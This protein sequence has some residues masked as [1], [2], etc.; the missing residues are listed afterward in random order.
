M[1][2]WVMLMDRTTS[3][4]DMLPSPVLYSDPDAQ[5]PEK[6]MPNPKIRPATTLWIPN[7]A[8]WNPLIPVAVTNDAVRLKSTVAIMMPTN[9]LGTPTAN[10]S[11]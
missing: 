7:G 3:A 8:G 10:R 2:A 11:R 5:P 4:A 1:T 9:I 6:T